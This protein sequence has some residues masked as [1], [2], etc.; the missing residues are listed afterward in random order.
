MTLNSCARRSEVDSRDN[1]KTKNYGSSKRENIFV[2]YLRIQVLF[3]LQLLLGITSLRKEQ[4]E[5][6]RLFASWWSRWIW[7][8]TGSYFYCRKP[9]IFAPCCKEKFGERG[10]Q[11]LKQSCSSARTAG[12]AETRLGLQICL[13]LLKTVFQDVWNLTTQSEE[14]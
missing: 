5:D 3:K 2:Y 8:Y 4:K 11:R 1:K 7:M 6:R 14:P 9:S 12:K 10:S 13:R